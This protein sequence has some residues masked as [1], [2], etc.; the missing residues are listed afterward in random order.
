MRNYYLFFAITIYG[1]STAFCQTTDSLTLSYQR[2]NEITN[3]L[4]QEKQLRAA[5]LSLRLE[6]EKL[7]SAYQVAERRRTRLN[8]S[9]LPTMQQLLESQQRKQKD[10]Q[11]YI[12]QLT[13][14]LKRQRNKKWK[15]L[16]GGVVVGVITGLLISI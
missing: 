8:D 9:V 10:G 6:N 12:D 3:T 7:D 1:L 11:I 4:L 13:D 15:W 5:F 16:G 2:A 14:E